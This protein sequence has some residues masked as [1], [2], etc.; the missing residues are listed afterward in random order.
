MS[1]SLPE[2]FAQIRATC[3][4][5]R[6][7]IGQAFERAFG[8]LLEVSVGESG[9]LEAE[10]L[11]SEFAG[12]GLAITFVGAESAAALL[13]GESGGLVPSWY[14]APDVT[15][16]ARLATLAQELG[17]LCFPDSMPAGNFQFTAVASLIDFLRQLR[18]R[19][20]AQ[21]L[22]LALHGKSHDGVAKL[23]WPLDA[24]GLPAAAS[25]PDAARPKAGAAPQ[26]PSEGGKSRP[27]PMDEPA[28]VAESLPP[29]TRS[30]LHI[31]VPI[32]VTLA[33]KRQPIGQ[34]MD[35]GSG[36]IIHFEKS[37]EEMLDLYVGQHRVARG[38]AVK[39]GEKFGLRITSVILPEERFS[40]VER[41]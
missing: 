14:A 16:K 4:A 12:P 8:E 27:V 6:D 1:T 34:I 9:S 22:D 11:P 18:S 29:Y 37:C 25:P 28:A 21:S 41:R 15:Q 32:S 19:P 13:L 33:T 26:A 7:E 5:A 39:V 17:I 38:E 30:L 40:I 20:G 36:S 31:E 24:V 23:V 3:E 10:R 2:A 35:L